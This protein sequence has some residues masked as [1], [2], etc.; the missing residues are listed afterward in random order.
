M[1]IGFKGAAAASAL[2]MGV[3]TAFA[4]SVTQPGET[5]GVPA[6]APLPEGVYFANTADWAA[7]IQI[8]PAASASRFPLLRG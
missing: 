8:Q 5:V 1:K 4:G 7:G 2:L 6:G 3:P